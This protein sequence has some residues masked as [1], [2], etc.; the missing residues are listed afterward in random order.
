PGQRRQCLI[1]QLMA[2]ALDPAA[3]ELVVEDLRPRRDFVHVDDLVAA[4]CMVPVAEEARVFNVGSGRSHS[5]AEIADMVQRA[6]GTAKP[7]AARGGSRAEEIPAAVAE[8]AAIRALG[9]A[10]RIEPAPGL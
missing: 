2:Q 6:A 1:P 5:V 4:L 3:P 10:P 9:R 7:V 8:I